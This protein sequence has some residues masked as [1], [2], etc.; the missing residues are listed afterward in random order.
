MRQRSRLAFRH[1][2]QL[3]GGL[4]RH[5]H[6][7]ANHHNPPPRAFVLVKAFGSRTKAMSSSSI[8]ARYVW[9]PLGVVSELNKGNLAP[10]RRC[11][12]RASP[13]KPC[14]QCQTAPRHGCSAAAYNRLCPTRTC[15]REIVQQI[16]VQSLA[17][18]PTTCKTHKLRPDMMGM[19]LTRDPGAQIVFNAPFVFSGIHR[20]FPGVFRDPV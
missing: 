19:S 11:N 6:P 2:M 16:C 20:R 4:S 12:K 18:K 14:P 15:T 8:L 10:S 3:T 1:D 13:R 5:R 9:R 17:C 7:V